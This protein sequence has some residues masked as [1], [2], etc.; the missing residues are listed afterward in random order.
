VFFTLLP[1]AGILF[2]CCF[3]VFYT[4]IH[5]RNSKK[6]FWGRRFS[7]KIEFFMFFFFLIYRKISGDIAFFLC[8]NI[9]VRLLNSRLGHRKPAGI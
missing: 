9:S 3:R 6:L 4:L 8:Y 5:T 1:P 7:P 2:D